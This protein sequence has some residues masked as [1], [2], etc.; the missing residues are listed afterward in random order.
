MNKK[1]TWQE[2]DEIARDIADI[3]S[4]HLSWERDELID[5][6]TKIIDKYYE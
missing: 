6:I 5:T 2:E 1:L 4:G 3:L